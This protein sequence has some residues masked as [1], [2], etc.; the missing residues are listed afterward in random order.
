MILSSIVVECTSSRL[1][2]L[3]L[4]RLLL[5]LVALLRRSL[6][7]LLIDCVPVGDTLFNLFQGLRV[8]CLNCFLG[9]SHLT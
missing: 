6:L 7:I 5:M 2:L 4:P 3:R 1:L 9:A 8:E